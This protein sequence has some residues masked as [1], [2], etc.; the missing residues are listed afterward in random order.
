MLSCH[1][2]KNLVLVTD[3]LELLWAPIL[4]NVDNFERVKVG[5]FLFAHCINLAEGALT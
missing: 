1:L 4:V 5:S 2:L 3:L